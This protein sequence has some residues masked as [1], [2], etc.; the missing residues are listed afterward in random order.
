[1]ILT[2][3]LLATV[4][5]A[6]PAPTLPTQHLPL[7]NT[8]V[9]ATESVIDTASRIKPGLSHDASVAEVANLRA[10]AAN[11]VKLAQD[12]RDD[13]EKDIAAQANDLVFAVEACQLQS[14]QTPDSPDNAKCQQQVAH[15]SLR[16]MEAIGKHK[17]GDTWVDGPPQSV[18]G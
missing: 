15:A 10:I 11:L 4:L 2:T 1:M 16:L 12:G 18:G 8:F 5:Q 13:R 6:A 3:F 7:R 17:A 14:G 9:V